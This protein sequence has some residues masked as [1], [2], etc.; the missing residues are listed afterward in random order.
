MNTQD[1]KRKLT[2]LFSADLAGPTGSEGGLG[3]GESKN[4]GSPSLPHFSGDSE[5]VKLKWRHHGGGDER[6]G[7]ETK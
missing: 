6:G 1:F 3:E 2:A 7:A 5:A 4:M